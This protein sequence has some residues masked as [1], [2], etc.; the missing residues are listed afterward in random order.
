MSYT[1]FEHAGLRV[2]IEPDQDAEN[3]TSWCQEWRIVSFNSRHCNFEHPD[4]YM[5]VSIGLRRKLEVG[6]A[7]F[8]SYYEHGLCR[9]SLSGEG[10]TC[11]WDSVGTA[12]IMLYD[13]PGNM[14]AKDYE[15][16]AKDARGFLETYTPWCNGDVWGYIIED[17]DGETL[18]SCWGYC[19][20]DDATEQ[21]KAAAEYESAQLAKEAQAEASAD[22]LEAS[23]RVSMCYEQ[24]FSG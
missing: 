2:R 22:E 24:A 16:R 11:P 9:W 5:P 18:D 21:A 10:S 4:N 23:R 14:G 12:G 19:G 17:A 7:F 1:D 6:T 8:L 15:G 3:P 20:M 13:N